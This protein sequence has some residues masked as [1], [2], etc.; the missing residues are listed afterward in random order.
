MNKHSEQNAADGDLAD[1]NQKQNTV[2]DAG[3]SSL[4][5]SDVKDISKRMVQ[6]HT[7]H[8]RS[9]VESKAP[10]KPALA[11]FIAGA[12]ATANAPPQVR[13][14]KNLAYLRG[15]HIGNAFDMAGQ[16]G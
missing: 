13:Y 2:L 5:R 14:K 8:A 12:S 3:V 7:L 9:K 1:R 15:F 4:P 10:S 16:L 11:S 6:T